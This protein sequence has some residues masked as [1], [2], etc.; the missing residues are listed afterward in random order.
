MLGTSFSQCYHN[1]FLSSCVYDQ[2][3]KQSPSEAG[4]PRHRHHCLQR[5]EKNPPP[6]FYLA[7]ALKNNHPGHA[8][9]LPIISLIYPDL[10]LRFSFLLSVFFPS[11][12]PLI[13]CLLLSLPL[14]CSCCVLPYASYVLFFLPCFLSL[15]LFPVCLPPILLHMAKKKSCAVFII[16][17]LHFI[18]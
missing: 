4:V 15:Y 16:Q 1:G 12:L 9:L 2:Y 17:L 13:V 7:R 14:F 18:R 8:P 5:W 3:L 10:S 11:C 6:L